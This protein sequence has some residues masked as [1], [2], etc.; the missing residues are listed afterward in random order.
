[1]VYRLMKKMQKFLM[2][3]TAT[4]PWWNLRVKLLV[5]NA[6]LKITL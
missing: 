4:L 6:I 1:M 3:L 5:V 2:S